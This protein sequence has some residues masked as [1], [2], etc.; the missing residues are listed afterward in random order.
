MHWLRP[1]L[2]AVCLAH[3]WASGVTG[4]ELAQAIHDQSLDSEACFHVRELNFNKEDAKFYLTD[5]YLIFAKPILGQRLFAIFSAEVEGGD[6][7][8]LLMPP[9][10]SERRSL[11]LFAGSPNL[12]EHF[13]TAL[14]LFSDGTGEEL[15]A[16]ASE[17]GKKTADMGA[18]MTERWSPVARNISAGFEVRLVQ[19]LLSADRATGLFFAALSG[20]TLG[21]FDIVHDPLGRDQ[22]VAGQYTTR[23][24]HPSFDIWTS[25]ES[26]SIRTGRRKPP[27]P[28][29]KLSDYRIDAA[30]DS[31]LHMQATTRATLT[32]T[33]PLRAFAFYVSD[34]V[35]IT[36]VT[37][38]GKPAELYA[39]ESVR[40][41]AI[42]GGGN[43]TFVAI[44]SDPVAAGT[45]HEIEIKHDG[46]VVIPAGNNVYY[47]TS[48]GNW[49][50]RSGWEFANYDLTFRYPKRLT[51]V[52]TG[53]TI[54]NRIDGEMRVSRHKTTGAIRVAG[55]NLGQYV[56]VKL[57][58]SGYSIEVFGNEKLEPGLQP[59]PA[60][61]L[62]MPM[63]RSARRPD[64][65]TTAV[66][67][68]PPVRPA[69]RLAALAENI[70]GAFDFMRAEFGPPPIKSLTV[71]PIPGAF[72]Q[73]FPG[74]VYLSTLAYLRQ[75]ERPA[76]VRNRDDETFFNELLPAH[77]VAHQWWGNSVSP[78]GYEDEW[79]ME[80]LANYSSLLYLEKRRGSKPV[81]SLL[82][83]FQGH[84]LHKTED[85]RTIESAGPITWGLRLQSSQN[86]D[87]WR[88]ITYEKGAWIIHML[89]R[90][91]G[92]ERFRRL[93]AETCKRYAHQPLTTGQF[94]RLAEEMMGPKAGAEPLGEF[95][96]SWV[97]GTGI[98]SLKLS[99]ALKGRAPALKLTGT[100]TQS[101]VED[102]FAVEVPIEIYQGH[103]APITHWVRTSNEPVS[104]SFNLKQPPSRVVLPA[105][106]VLA[107][108]K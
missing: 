101:G 92:D 83:T 22:I 19:D 94:R 51:L 95:F 29:F 96:E 66:P 82:E 61:L 98:P 1:A 3:A 93:L 38:D 26:R 28:K 88:V 10:R 39:R 46:D 20:N 34:K 77:E 4:P 78:G 91:M 18:L 31:A 76:A 106:A 45:N 64:L 63:P 59:K 105:A 15:L 40:A 73:G 33:V 2:I 67:P 68:A 90:R 58:R 55:F 23:G 42:R 89:R 74:L 60:I 86:D 7:E 99:W 57:A 49:Y 16:S 107:S 81:E 70:A 12:D 32:A 75:D 35:R 97:Y 8:I 13:R 36:D 84:L 103:G 37:I 30:L 71:S 17:N 44:T 6:A 53:D 9:H 25:F 11:A 41:S 102:D 72:G 85:G 14:F 47:V 54:E 62:P 52:A 69:S 27:T 24:A 43:T 79:L 104:F 100:L 50:P 80:A 48:R 108:R 65:A 21:N 56:N 5:G 87:A